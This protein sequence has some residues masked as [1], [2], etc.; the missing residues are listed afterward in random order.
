[1]FANILNPPIGESFVGK[2]LNLLNISAKCFLVS[3]FLMLVAASA[4]TVLVS[5]GSWLV[6]A[7]DQSPSYP[8]YPGYSSYSSYHSYPGYSS[9]PAPGQYEY[10]P[11]SRRQDGL[12]LLASPAL[13]T[14][15]DTLHTGGGGLGRMGAGSAW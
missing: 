7:R 13:A 15:L 6:G 8:S 5:L 14:I 10:H 2:C 11:Q 9:Y 1:M 12:G 3:V 4:L